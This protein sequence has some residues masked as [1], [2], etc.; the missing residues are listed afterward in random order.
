M[1]A[2]TPDDHRLDRVRVR[3][4]RENNLRDVDVD[5][6]RDAL[7]AFTGV[8]GS[9]K[10]SLAFGTLYAEAQ[11]R[12]FESVAPY[13]RRL[14]D[15]VGVPDVDAIDGLP[16]AV[17][18]PQRRSGGSARSTLGSATTLSS[19]VR[20]VFSRVG[21]YPEG[22]PMLLAEDFSANTVQGACPACHGIGRVY[23][24]PEELMVPDGSLSIRDGA[25]AAWPTAWHGKQLRD[26]LISLGYDI[27][28]PWTT[29]PAEEREWI[30]YTQES[31]QVPVWTD[32]GPAEVRAAVAAGAE[33]RYMS[34]FL[35]V[36]RYVMD[37]FA[38]SKSARMRE[39][40]ATFLVSVA[41]PDCHGKRVK[42]EA[43][44]V[45]FEGLDITELSALP[46]EELAALLTRVL[47]PDWIPAGGAPL[48]PETRLAAQ[49]LV[50]D[51]LGRMAPIVDLGLG[52][53]SLDRSTPTLSSG[54]LQRMRL[55]TQ[56][57]SRLFGV[58][59]VLDEPSTG[60]HPADT[61]ALL[62]ILRSLKDSGNTVF[63]VEHSLD[64]IREAD[65]IVDIGPAAG[66]GGGTVVYSGELAGLREA[67]DS[68]TRRYL[69]PETAEPTPPLPVRRTPDAQVRLVDVARNNLRGL[70]V[71]FPLGALTAV[72][73]VSGSGKSTLV[74]QALPD[75][76]R[77]SLQADLAGESPEPDESS[78]DDPL[79]DADS[80][81]TTGSATGPAERLRRVVQVGQT[82]IGRT[83]RSNVA[84][85]T[86]LFDR[87]RALFA[88]TPEAKRRRY[89]AGRFS[90]NMPSGRCPV[91]KGEGT[92]E[93]ELLFL[94][95]V[96][97]PCTACGGTRYNAE[98]LEVTWGGR[99]IADVL[100]LSVTE[101]REV[102]A[103]ETEIGRH[104]DALLDVGLGY[105]ALGQPA[106][107]LSGGEAQRVKL[108]SELRRAQRGDTL[109]LLDE[110]TSGLH[111]A[112]ADRLLGHLQH[113][114]DAG[115]TVIVVEHDMR[116]VADADW[117]IDLGPGAGDAGGSIVATGTPEQVAR[118]DG[119]RTAPYLLAALERRG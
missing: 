64:V 2:R 52:Y 11:R 23:D 108:A 118:A 31:P 85:Y 8:S 98:T 78:S 41:C 87:V 18:L 62:G 66:S 48:P 74:N 83:S 95:T 44:A 38:G 46:L 58:V 90:F 4:A 101:A 111:P 10:S 100:A 75:L 107:E 97:A 81:V 30:L 5:I 42:P 67:G 119:S 86:G 116:I 103:E 37:T 117:V 89:G 59:F 9:G 49:R 84:T 16:P 112:D 17:A 57:L 68:I 12:Y 50:S 76:L 32:R 20:M 35:G 56:V 110:P 91:C 15:Q 60:L 25:L 109:Y 72:T 104:L 33:P 99:S 80:G 14:I 73:G 63:F 47:E 92:M 113:L 36:R 26:S 61:E 40:A 88:A 79:L 6:P 102:F 82:P 27:D 69:F 24:V 55:A 51:L 7:V 115:N 77:A 114:V 19:V 3:G 54:E 93:V 13:A 94:P 71:A 1:T 105:V 106:P 65:W 45:S 34:T 22:A 39:R 21:T 29:L 96:Q 70:D 43:L 28:V 53:L